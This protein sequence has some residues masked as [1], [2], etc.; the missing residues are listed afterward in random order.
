MTT[1]VEE[2][3]HTSYAGWTE[4]R[5]FRQREW[6]CEYRRQSRSGTPHYR[7]AALQFSPLSA[8]EVAEFH[9]LAKKWQR[10]TAIYGNLSKIVM[11]SAYQ[12]IMAMGKGVVPLILEELSKK[13]SHW[14]WALHNLVPEG[15]DPAEGTTTIDEA[16]HA[17]LEW[18]KEQG[19]L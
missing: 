8:Q 17:W 16:T 15:T 18:G 3:Y 5:R 1:A 12:R 4:S 11:H 10:E 14:F 13:K 7:Q 2:R 6:G 9:A 19:I